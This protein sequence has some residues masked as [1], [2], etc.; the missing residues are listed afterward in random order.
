MN[1]ICGEFEYNCDTNFFHIYRSQL[2][3]LQLEKTRL[4]TRCTELQSAVSAAQIERENMSEQYTTLLQK[5]NQEQK[6]IKLQ[7]KILNE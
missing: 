5:E 4:V 3:T 1:I 2:D 7:V 6:N